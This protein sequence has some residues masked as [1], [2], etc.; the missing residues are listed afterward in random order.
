VDEQERT[1]NEDVARAIAAM[2][3]RLTQIGLSRK[4][5]EALQ[6]QHERL[7]RKR[8]ID[9]AAVFEARKA[10]LEELAGQQDLLHDVIEWK[11][12]V[13]RLRELQ[14][15]LGRDCGFACDGMCD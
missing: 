5:L 15:E 8:E 1:L 4:R 11:L 6:A 9:A 12:A 10:R 14:G 2:E 7:E 3:A 13:A